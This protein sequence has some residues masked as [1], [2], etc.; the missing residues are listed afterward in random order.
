MS[1]PTTHLRR[2]TAVVVGA[3]AVLAT[4][5]V[6]ATVVDRA[7][8]VSTPAERVW[9]PPG[10]IASV[11][12]V[13]DVDAFV[14]EASYRVAERVGGAAAPGRTGSVGLSRI[15]RGDAVVHAPPAGWLIPMVYLAFP[16]SALGGLYGFDVSRA[17]DVDTVVLN[18]LTARNTG[19]AEGDVLDLSAPNGSTQSFVVARILPYEAIGGTELLMSVAAAERIGAL[20]DTRTVIY[21]I[22]SRDAFDAAAS[23][24]GLTGR[25]DT[26]VSRSWDLRDPDGTLSSATAKTLL[27]E[28]WYRPLT[29]DAIEMHP[30]WKAEHL[31]DGRV[32]L[33]PTIRVRAQCN[34]G[35][36]ADLGA[37]LADVA[38]AGLAS[39]IDVANTNTYGG[40]FA[41]RYSRISGFLSRHAYAM[42]IDMNTLSNCQGCTPRMNCDVVRIFR[43]HG[44]AWGG[45][46]RRPDGMHF[47]WVG[48]PRDQI[49]YPSTY[50][51]NLVSP[52]AQA[53]HGDAERGTEVLVAG[54]G[55][56][57]DEH[58][59]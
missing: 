12:D 30:T 21:G 40:C 43:K 54:V 37:A 56:G 17:L 15:V 42:A 49:G 29:G 31:T 23:S 48:E 11:Y 10:D 6:A 36:V 44:F 51:P 38:A 33:D 7:A 27:G 1:V 39:A 52:L 50:C 35:I 46:F 4:V 53:A 28:P 5:A 16:D 3:V 19:T 2:F 22:G 24:E 58:E 14:V 20:T 26:K 55:D 25:K 34:L 18:E 59:A 9:A 57:R 45:N 8:T 13:E 41:P 32:L 47:E